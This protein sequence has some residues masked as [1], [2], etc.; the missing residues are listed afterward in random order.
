[1]HVSY[2]LLL[3][4]KVLIFFFTNHWCGAQ[5]TSQYIVEFWHKRVEYVIEYVE[6]V[7]DSDG[8]LVLCIML[9]VLDKMAWPLALLA[10]LAAF[11]ASAVL[12]QACVCDVSVPACQPLPNVTDGGDTCV[13]IPRNDCPCCLVCAGQ[14]GQ[15]CSGSNAPC[16]V[17]NHM[18]CDP[19]TARCKKGRTTKCSHENIY[20]K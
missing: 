5:K 10:F 12:G 17:T 16:D 19:D 1:M 13:K 3:L 2:V 8:V 11:A 15:P 20:L 14:L 18:V 7:K 6:V 4:R 9:L